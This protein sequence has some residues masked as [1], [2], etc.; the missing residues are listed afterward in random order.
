M[1]GNV[2]VNSGVTLTIEPGVTVQG[3]SSS[4]TLTI[5]GSL[6]AE[7]TSGSHI[8]FTS[9]SDSA[10]GQWNGITFG[11]TAGA[12]TLAYVDVRYGGDS[13]ASHTNSMV[14][15]NGGELTIE[16][17]TF[18]QSTVTGLKVSGGTNG[19]AASATITRTKF[20]A[21]GYGGASPHGN[22]LYVNNAYVE[23][24]DSAFW[25]NQRD[26]IYFE[27]SSGY[28]PDPSVVTD[29]SFW[30]NE[31]YGV[32]IFQGTGADDLGP[33]GSG[34]ALYDNGDFTFA[35]GDSWRQ[36]IILR[37]SL[38]V[39]WS[40][41]YWGPV[42]FIPCGVGSENGHLSYGAPD[43]NPAT[44]F[45]I[46]RGPV[47]HTLQAEGATWCGNDDLLV[48]EPAY[49]LPDLYFDAPPPTFGGLPLE[50]TFGSMNCQ[51]DNSIFSLGSDAQP[52][53][54]LTYT[55]RP[56]STSSGSLS[57]S[58]IDLKL[59]GPG[60]PFE[61]IRSYNSRDTTAGGLGTG[62]THPYE[63][64]ITVANPTTGELEYRAGSGQRIAFTK[65]TGGGTG[66]ATYRGKGFDGTM[67][68]L[69]DNS[70]EMKTRDQR[71]FLFDT[72]GKLTQIKPRFLPAATLTYSSGKLSSITDSAGR[73]VSLTYNVADPSLIERVTL[74]DS[75]YVEYGYTSGRLASVLD[76]RGET[77][78]LSYDGSGRLTD[79]ED[80]TGTFLLQDVVYDGSGR[81][82]S[83]EDG[84]GESIEY[85]YS[86]AGGYDLTTVTIPGRGDWVYKHRGNLLFHVTDPLDRTTSYTYD[87]MGRRATIKDP[88]GKVR[89]FEYDAFGNVTKEVAPA[90]LDYTTSR[91]FNATN[92]LLIETDG[93]D[94]STI[95]TYASSSNADYQAGQLQEIQDRED[96]ETTFTY[97]TTTSSPTPPSTNVGLLKSVENQRG[98]TTTYDYDSAGNLTKI[99]SPLGFETTIGY[100]SSG[101]LTSRRD[102]RG[103]VP[104]PPA[105]YL[106]AWSYEGGD[107]VETITDARGNVTSFAYHENGL[108]ASV[109]REEEDT[110][111]RT[112][113]FVYDDANRL[114]TT[115]D[116]RNGVETRLYWPDGQ[117]ASV[118]SPEGR[119]TTY[120]YDDA[121]Q[122]VELVEPNGNAGTAS[123]YTWTYG[124]DDAGNRTS[125]A[126]PDGGTREIAYDAL[127]R[128]TSW[129]DALD[130]VVS[131]E[132][133]AN[134]NVTKRTNDLEDFRTYTY[135]GLDRLET[136]TDERQLDPWTYEHFPT[137]E[138]KT[139][140]SP[141]G[142]KTTYELD[143]D[144]RTVEM[145]EP[146]GNDGVNDPA[147][148]T[149][150]YGY[151]EAGNRTS[152]T[153]PLGNEVAY[154]YDE[155]GNV[156]EVEDERGNSTL[157]EFDTMNR[158][159][160]VTPPAAGA[161]G[162][163]E[164]TYAYDPAG[165]LALR[166]DPKGHETSW[167][168]DLDGLLTQRT[169]EVG[170]W[171]YT[172]DDN[173]NL[174]TL[175]TPAGSSTGTVGDGTITYGYDRMGRFTEVDYSD[176][177]PD[178]SRD[179]DLAGRLEEMTDGA[180]AVTY[181]FDEL[182]RL[183]S[184]TR[185]GGGSGL[186]GSFAY[187]YDEAGNILER[188]YPDS[189]V[190]TSTFDDDGRLA[191]VAS[192]GATTTFGYDEAGNITTVTLPAGNGH[193][194]NRTFDEAGR[195]TTVENEDGSTVL[196]TFSWT[197]D[198]AGNPT[199][200]QTTRGVTDTYD[201]FE[202]DTRNRLTASC[203]GTSS[204]ASDCSGASNE[205]TYA[206][207]KVS[208]R[209]EEVRTGSVGST[210]TIT[211]DYNA[212]DQLTQKAQGSSTSYTYD[213]NGNQATAGSRTFTYD[214]AD[215]LVS[216]T[217][218]SVTTTY[219]YDGDD[220]RVSST[221]A[222]GADLNLTWD[223]LAETGIPELALERE[224]DGDLARRYL[225]GPLG[226][227]SMENPS[228][229][230]YY[231]QDPLG[232]VTD[233]TD[234]DGDPQWRYTYEAYGAQLSA[235]NV[236]GTAPENRLRYTGQYL[237]PETSLYHLRAR[238]Y[239]AGI[240]RFHGT[241]PIEPP[242]DQPYVAAYG[243]VSGRPTVL[244]DP[245]GRQ[246][247]GGATRAEIDWCLEHPL[248][249][250]S[251]VIAGTLAREVLD[252][253]A[254]LFPF[255]V[256]LQDSFQHCAWAASLTILLGPRSA[257]DFTRRHEE[258]AENCPAERQRDLANNAYGI[259][260]GIMSDPNSEYQGG[261]LDQA[262]TYCYRAAILG[263][264][265]GPRRCA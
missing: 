35:I 119:L 264:L 186:N 123:D 254:D 89:R 155:V 134:G 108:L 136:E 130:H 141:L 194:A 122:L 161:T 125:E 57:E 40:G 116:P 227:I 46:E 59:A 144:G 179:Y 256:E 37:D 259:L 177:T 83:E 70:Y 157:F 221:V 36:L 253:A 168:Y 180:G 238:Q 181:G 215:R 207:D 139:V 165:N 213:A 245:S 47:S 189:T 184:A 3:N 49:E 56:V 153:D 261:G 209:T 131:V 206:Y 169:T 54:G 226:A 262:L 115:T 12:S 33:D 208:N 43:P 133:D 48:N 142:F 188:T 154:A 41:N 236:S 95:Y 88:R 182:D 84:A 113:S 257:Y 258:G 24:D 72:G 18:T 11:T 52:G 249:L 94:N 75:R 102:P 39:D 173:G 27:V 164:T 126:H 107:E 196:S 217:A 171:N 263:H 17:A 231:H 38:E 114:W 216:T 9:A 32:N 80:P 87:A 197:L 218:S 53:N 23:I 190:V 8:V 170:T 16:D 250:G 193:V 71:T 74:P 42:H 58:Y 247:I 20:E 93:R 191:T 99:T 192:G 96:G 248:S 214:L 137:G 104:D 29:S 222:G 76:A 163:L 232:T 78:T 223:P 112:T 237:D 219:A 201:A 147:D 2:T 4:R 175:E 200:A 92:D 91:Q 69:S 1:T 205:I 229:T 151:D 31:R 162:T 244:I 111:E 25:S 121:G 187:A 68:R 240:G 86:T 103:N 185:T 118:E 117:L 61:W 21:N 199:K 156:V 166:T 265:V 132:Y 28:T 62:W 241:D 212:A 120:E 34:N 224:D 160:E 225:T 178:V 73:T 228:E 106:T 82:T 235:T 167:D 251:C 77:W 63:A 239:D 246:Q 135:D 30:A 195:L 146:R 10:P 204:M 150:T 22:G 202:Y 60:I 159:D 158:L 124:Y 105:G 243:Y 128:P 90:P 79:I 65:V 203:Y 15:V 13:G 98:K 7:G 110:T 19:T 5:N 260:L 127:N 255:D 101:R 234:E 100:D 211:Y 149:W 55:S 50:R 14:T 66:A 172:Y 45:P 233:L 44:S 51:I 143:E 176:S 26:G 140:L 109:T 230:F 252:L 198:A 67:K 242:H 138:L 97:W 81:V 64:K 183:E 148:Y 220:R 152:V 6:S 85:A 129:E 174:E 210:G 145:V